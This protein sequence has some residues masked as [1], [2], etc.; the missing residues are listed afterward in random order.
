MQRNSDHGDP[1]ALALLR[2][3]R[4]ILALIQKRLAELG[5]PNRIEIRLALRELK[6]LRRAIR[7]GVD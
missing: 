7:E 6:A 1:T 3:Q 5:P 4:R 2:L